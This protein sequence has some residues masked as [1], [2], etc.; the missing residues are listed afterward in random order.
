MS[1][2]RA[3]NRRNLRLLMRHALKMPIAAPSGWGAE[4][5]REYTYGV[6][7]RIA[8]YAELMAYDLRT[9]TLAQR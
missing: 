1:I 6:Y 3:S 2:N 9:G 8:E 5:W 7:N 4:S